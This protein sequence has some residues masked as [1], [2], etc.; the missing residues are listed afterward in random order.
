MTNLLFWILGIRNLHNYGDK[1]AFWQCPPA[2]W[3]PKLTDEK[4]TS[5]KDLNKKL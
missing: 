5:A 4:M 2:K 3:G 1:G